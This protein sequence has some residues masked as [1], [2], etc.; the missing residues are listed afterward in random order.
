MEG[1]QLVASYKFKK[2]E[3]NTASSSKILIIQIESA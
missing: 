1:K 3:I 2:I